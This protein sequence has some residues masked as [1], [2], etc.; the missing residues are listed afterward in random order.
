MLNF[1]NHLNGN[2]STKDMNVQCNLRVSD[3]L[4]Q[5]IVPNSD[6]DNDQVPV[7][8]LYSGCHDDS[9]L[10]VVGIVDQ[11]NHGIN[12]QRIVHLTKIKKHFENVQKVQENYHRQVRKRTVTNHNQTVLRTTR[13]SYKVTDDSYDQN[14]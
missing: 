12:H 10:M 13:S 11:R 14:C 5:N 7:V 6:L 1:V 2:R 3:F 4:D 9:H 8:N